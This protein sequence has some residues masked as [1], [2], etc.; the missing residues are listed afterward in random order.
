[1][2]T[3]GIDPKH[4]IFAANEGNC[5]ALATGYHLATGKVPVVFIIGWRGESGIHDEPQHIYQGKVTA[6]LLVDMGNSSFIIGKDSSD[7]EVEAAMEG[8]KNSC[9]WK[10]CGVCHS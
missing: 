5:T 9:D 1:M 10:R 3:Y 4:H 8:L 6:K 7:D 2:D